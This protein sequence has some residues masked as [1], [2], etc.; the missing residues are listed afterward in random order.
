MDLYSELSNGRSVHDQILLTST[1]GLLARLQLE[2]LLLSAVLPGLMGASS[3]KPWPACWD[4]RPLGF[5]VQISSRM[6]TG[7]TLLLWHPSVIQVLFFIPLFP[8]FVL[9][10]Q[11]NV[12]LAESSILGNYFRHSLPG[13]PE[14]GFFL[15]FVP[16]KTLR[17][18]E[19]QGLV[20]FGVG[21]PKT[22]F[23]GSL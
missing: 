16:E 3:S 9:P 21:I 14:L 19:A 10:C 2:F 4:Q 22:V 13:D 6:A 18:D 8:V 7:T 23:I 20:G 15:K 12:A 5:S 11:R 17:N 1:S